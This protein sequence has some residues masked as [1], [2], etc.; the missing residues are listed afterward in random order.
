MSVV[1]EGLE[2]S[3]VIIQEG[4]PTFESI[5]DA[6][7]EPV[8]Y[9]IDRFVVG[10][11]YR[12]HTERGKDENLNAPGAQVRA[13]R[14]RGAVHP[15]SRRAGGLRAQPLLRLRRRRA[16]CATGGGHRSRGARGSR[17]RRSGVTSA[18]HAI[19]SRSPFCD[20]RAIVLPADGTVQPLD[21]RAAVC[22]SRATSTTMSASA[23]AARSS[24]RCT[25]RSITCC[26]ATGCGSAA[27]S[28][29]LAR[30]PRSARTCSRTSTSL[31]ASA[32]APIATFSIGRAT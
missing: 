2:V 1:K 20:D 29:S 7:A 27:S 15:R 31:R 11:F 9:M 14:V 28:A 8:V 3:S 23:I 30:C 6:I 21:E 19:G 18:G 22:A 12:V 24:A 5:H 17:R 4:V 16:T 25:A 13:A 10:G 32:S 26:G